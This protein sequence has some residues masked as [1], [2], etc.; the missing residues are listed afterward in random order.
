M[1]QQP[2]REALPGVR[3]ELDEAGTAELVEHVLLGRLDAAFVR[4]PIGTVAGL[5]VELVLEEPMLAA[6]PAGHPLS[7][8]EGPP[9]PLTAT[10]REPSTRKASP[11]DIAFSVTPGSADSAARTRS[12]SSRS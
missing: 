5:V 12:A 4:S 7:L 11:P 10:A 8:P 2:F 6:L 1:A 3:M 9:L